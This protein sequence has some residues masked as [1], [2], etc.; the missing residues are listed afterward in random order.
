MKDYIYKIIYTRIE[1]KLYIIIHLLTYY[2]KKKGKT[3]IWGN[4]VTYLAYLMNYFVYIYDIK[5][6]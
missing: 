6:L 3:F 2:L 4:S 1:L 5:F